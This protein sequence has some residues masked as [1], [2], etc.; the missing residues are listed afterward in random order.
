[1]IQNYF[2]HA[3]WLQIAVAGIA[4]FVLGA[5]W[6]MPALFG[7]YWAEKHNI[8]MNDDSKR[9]MPMLM[10]ATFLL[11][12]AMAVGMGLLLYLMQSPGTC[13]SGIKAGLFVGG[14]FCAAPIAINY[15]YTAKPIKLWFI[16]AGYHVAGI[17]LMGIILSVWH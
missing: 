13:T 6:Y 12:I 8:Q 5:V 3:P 1:M 14:I 17:T 9:R 10:V 11:N 4:Y 16:D 2:S 15:L 7:K